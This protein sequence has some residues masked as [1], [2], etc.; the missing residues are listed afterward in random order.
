MFGILFTGAMWLYSGIKNV[1]DDSEAMSKPSEEFKDGI[2]VYRDRK[3]T[4]Y[5]NGEKCYERTK[6]DEYGNY[7]RQ[8]VGCSSGRIY[9]D[10]YQEVLDKRREEERKEI[11]KQK[12]AG[13]S[14]YL[15]YYEEARQKLTTEISTGKVIAALSIDSL[16][17]CKKYY[18]ES[19]RCY[20]HYDE[21]EGIPISIDEMN[22][23]NISFGSHKVYDSAWQ[24]RQEINRMKKLY[25]EKGEYLPK[26]Y[27][28]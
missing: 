28:W 19:N 12:K 10:S 13:Y 16:G 15:K 5:I 9:H 22:A 14:A 1:I 26:N 4:P 6:T 25:G 2:T 7:H 20:W 3:Y 11:E 27:K 18:A 23:L 21:K 24:R 17:N 8:Y